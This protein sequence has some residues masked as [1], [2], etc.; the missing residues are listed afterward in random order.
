[1]SERVIIVG[2]VH[3]QRSCIEEVKRVIEQEAPSIVAIE[4]PPNFVNISTAR[5]IEDQMHRVSANY[6]RV[7]SV[8]K[9]MGFQ[10]HDV[11]RLEDLAVGISLQG[12]EFLEAI[13]AAKDIGA[14]VKFI[15]MS[16][17]RL[18]WEYLRE[19]FENGL[20][21]QQQGDARGIEIFPGIRLPAI[22]VPGLTAI[23]SSFI[24]VLGEWRST[25]DTLTAIYSEKDYRTLSKVI[26]PLLSQVDENPA[27]KEILV[28]YRNRYMVDHLVNLL[29]QT[30][31][32]IL[33]V[34]GFGHV[35]GIRELLDQ[36][37]GS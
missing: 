20:N 11:D 12:Y 16:R 25:L 21:R 3:G 28:E 1:M 18:F 7:F 27:F 29:G 26:Q 14:Q 24:Q 36:R 8:L 35:E 5:D 33:L 4:L 19:T 34:T 13:Q 31:G 22:K 6:H 37:L 15:D 23:A 30:D 2:V 9:S 32:K 17:D 10:E